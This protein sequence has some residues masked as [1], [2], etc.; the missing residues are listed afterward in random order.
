MAAALAAL[1]CVAVPG[2][3]GLWSSQGV[4]LTV[5]DGD[6]GWLGLMRYNT[7]TITWSGPHYAGMSIWW[8]PQYQAWHAVYTYNATQGKYVDWVFL[9]LDS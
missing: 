7:G 4:H 9:Y 8:N 6:E 5:S 1:A 2:Y 3:V